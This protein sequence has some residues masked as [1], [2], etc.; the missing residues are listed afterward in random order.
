MKKH[1]RRKIPVY[2]LITITMMLV[3]IVFVLFDNE[4]TYSESINYY[5]G[6]VYSPNFGANLIDNLPDNNYVISPLNINKSLI[7]FY[8][9]GDNNTVKQIKS[10]YGL[11]ESL[12][13]ELVTNKNK[14]NLIEATTENEYT[15]NYQK[16]IK[17]LYDKN[18][19]LLTVDKINLLSTSEKENIQ[20]LLKKIN[21]NYSHLIG[22]NTI[23]L[24]DINKYKL[25]SKEINN[26]SY[27]I[28]DSIDYVLDRYESYNNKVTINN[29]N[30]LYY[31]QKLNKDF[32]KATSNLDISL[33]KNDNI[34][35]INNNLKSLNEN[36]KSVNLEENFD[37]ISLNIFEF[38]GEW[39]TNFNLDLIK[40]SEFNNGSY[41]T[42][43]EMMYEVED[44]F[45]ENYYAL[46]FKKN[47]QNSKYAFIGI[48]PKKDEYQASNININ[49][50]L[51]NEKKGPVKI[52][53][54]R[55]KINNEINLKNLLNNKIDFD[56]PNLTKI[57]DNNIELNIYQERIIFEV[58]DKGTINTKYHINQV[59]SLIEK[60]YK[61]EI[62]L[63]RPFIFMV[64]NTETNEPIIMGKIN[65]IG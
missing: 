31:N 63:N 46:A 47:Y 61:K 23:S 3:I 62:I 1:K 42:A 41:V 21:L 22:V 48:L 11:N 2:F 32:I 49:S 29:Y 15:K 52:G 25:R 10:Y 16:L 20:L 51:N 37:L 44:S 19:H 60:D 35:T 43:V 59:D 34:S 45:Y 56:K 27:N 24:K 58:G 38:N 8:C 50:L 33:I 12:A 30:Y 5:T 55:F 40:S 13:I 57:N 53:L 39:E 14:E 36:Y 18:Y 54:P 6:D 17:E 65:N 26:N 28:K 4:V 9:G 7:P 64:I